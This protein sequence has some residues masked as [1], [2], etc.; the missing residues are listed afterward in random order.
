VLR[1]SRDADA[2]DAVQRRVPEPILVAGRCRSGGGDGDG[3]AATVWVA[4]SRDRIYAFEARGD[5][6]GELLGSWAR[7]GDPVELRASRVTLGFSAHGPRLV[8]QAGRFH[9]ADRRLL[10]FLGDPTRD[11]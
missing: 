3:T 4:V 6:V 9:R 11:A 2:R 7:D 8:V 1:R 10:R 5:T